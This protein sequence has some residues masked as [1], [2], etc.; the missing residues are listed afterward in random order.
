M[1]DLQRIARAPGSVA[2]E[3]QELTRIR[4]GY[5]R[6]WWWCERGWVSS[7]GT[8]YVRGE[9]FGRKKFPSRELA[10]AYGAKWWNYCAPGN[11]F[12]I[13]YLGPVFFPQAPGEGQ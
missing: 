3:A 1:T 7:D 6:N 9:A 4:A 2:T 12:G 11:P 5:W 8:S 10:E 13:K